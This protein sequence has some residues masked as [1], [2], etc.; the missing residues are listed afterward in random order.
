MRR[1]HM[2][3]D[4]ISEHRKPASKRYRQQQRM[5]IDWLKIHEPDVWA[6][7]CAYT[8]KNGTT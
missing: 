6:A 2:T 5:G 7:I 4:E 1:R 3:A 8:S